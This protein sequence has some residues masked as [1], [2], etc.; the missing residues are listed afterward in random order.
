VD[1]ITCADDNRVRYW[2]LARDLNVLLSRPVYGHGESD[3]KGELRK[4]LAEVPKQLDSLQCL[5]ACGSGFLA[6]TKRGLIRHLRWK[7]APLQMT[8]G[9]DLSSSSAAAAAAAPL[10]AASSGAEHAGAVELEC[11][12]VLVGHEFSVI[13]LLE[14][15]YPVSD[16]SLLTALQG[17]LLNTGTSGL[18]QLLPRDL[19]GVVYEYSATHRV[20]SCSAD[21][22]MRL[23]NLD[24]AAEATTEQMVEER[25]AAVFQKQKADRMARVDALL[26]RKMKRRASDSGVAYASAEA[27]E[28]AAAKQKEQLPMRQL[29]CEA[30]LCGHAGWVLCMAA[31]PL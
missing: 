28:Q 20:L 24:G 14:L 2:R 8:E 6:G 11:D 7:A 1:L 26:D 30:S 3:E 23:W 31:C 9:S 22:T 27:D 5:A 13:D 4:G 16:P 19:V 18:S 12:A 29:T 25:G 17:A 21:R 15:P 10:P